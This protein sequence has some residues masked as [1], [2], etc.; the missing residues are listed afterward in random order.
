MLAKIEAIV[1]SMTPEERQNPKLMNPRRKTRIARGS[2]ND[3][4]E[5][6]RF[7]KQFEQASKV[8]KQ[9][10][11]GKRGLSGMMRGLGGGIPGGVF[12][13]GRR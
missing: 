13:K 6:N 12:P 2:G 9:F 11:G 1:L 7:I 5:V 8:M 10:G 3:I 4:S